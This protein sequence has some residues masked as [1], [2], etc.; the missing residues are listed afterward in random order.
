MKCFESNLKNRKQFV[1]FND[2]NSDHQELKCGVPQGS[3]LGPLL[4]LVYINDLNKASDIFKLSSYADDSMLGLSLC[5]SLSKCKLCNN[6]NK[7][8]A[9]FINNELSKVYEWLCL[10]KLSMNVDKTKFMIF[11]YTQRNIDLAEIPNLIIN[12]IKIERVKEIK[13]LGVI[14]DQG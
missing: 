1:E 6:T 11:K 13:Y 3:I 2:T 5:F 9:D 4:F 7:Y 10:N 14:F 12:N 8:S